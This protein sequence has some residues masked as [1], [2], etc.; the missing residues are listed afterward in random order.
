MKYTYEAMDCTGTMVNASVEADCYDD[1][2]KKVREQGLFVVKLIPDFDPSNEEGYDVVADLHNKLKAANKDRYF[3]ENKQKEAKRRLK[4]SYVVLAVATAN[5][6]FS[7]YGMFTRNHVITA[8]SLP[9]S[10]A[11]CCY[12]LYAIRKSRKSIQET[13]QRMKDMNA[14][15]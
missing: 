13:Q 11:V 2:V 7:F 12:G 15:G 1:A 8:I 9:I 5:M 10:L 3:F 6:V 4:I 14:N